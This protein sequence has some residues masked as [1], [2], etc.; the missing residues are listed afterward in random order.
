MESIEIAE[1]RRWIGTTIVAEDVVT[2]RLVEGYRATLEPYLA[3]V[4]NEEAPLMI[5]WCLAPDTSP[6]AELGVD[7][8][9]RKG[10]FLPPVPL[11]RRMWAGGEIEIVSP[12]RINDHVVRRSTVADVVLKE[13]R[14]GLLC[15]VAVLHEIWTKRGASLRERQTIVYRGITPKPSPA[16]AGSSASAD[17]ALRVDAEWKIEASSVLL[18]R[19][20]ALSFNSHRIH[21]DYLYATAVEGYPGLVVHG[22]LQATLLCNLAT[23]LLGK[24]PSR[25]SYRAVAPLFAGDTFVVRASQRGGA[26]I[27]CWAQDA[28]GR[29]TMKATAT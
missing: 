22:P 13:G 12:L 14:T 10:S 2:P 4:G 7:G 17:E 1:M 25:F 20:S 27:E 29:T 8:H 3:P 11:P 18:F 5:H 19:Y 23:A 16:E 9:A 15:F 26:A 21:Y 24:P 28:G 6:Q